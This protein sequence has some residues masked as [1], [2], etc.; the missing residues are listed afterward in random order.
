[1]TEKAEINCEIIGSIVAFVQ[2]AVEFV[3]DEN[4]S[5]DMRKLVHVTSVESQWKVIDLQMLRDIVKRLKTWKAG[6]LTS[7]GCEKYAKQL[8]SN[9]EMDLNKL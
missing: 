4:L 5:R 6:T 9:I 8:A 7:Q 2:D 1:M 3:D